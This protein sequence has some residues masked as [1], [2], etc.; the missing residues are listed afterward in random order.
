[1]AVLHRVSDFIDINQD[2]TIGDAI[3]S[4]WYEGCCPQSSDWLRLPRT[5]LVEA[6]A[7]GLMQQLATNAAYS[8]EGKMY[9]VLLVELPSREQRVLKAFSGLLNGQSQVEGWVPPISG[10]DQVALAE[11]QI[12]A[13]LDTLKQEI[14]TLQ[15]LPE[16]QQYQQLC[17]EWEQR[18]Q[19][20]RDRHRERKQQRQEKRQI[21]SEM[22][23]GL[24]LAIALQQLDIASRQ[25][26]VERR[27]LKQE[28]EM[29]LRSLEQKILEADIKIR[30]LKQQRKVLSH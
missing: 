7:Q 9:G 6:I 10:R 16:R 28:R 19:E 2:T 23:D 22:L 11:A 4:Y 8:Q 13:E 21:L 5:S 26:G 29:A 27:R 12:V 30:E 15:E 1:M 14:I 24:D 3:P 17:Q 25:D 20:M 18:F